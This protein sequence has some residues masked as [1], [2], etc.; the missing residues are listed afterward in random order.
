[1]PDGDF[2][3][4]NSRGKYLARVPK[5]GGDAEIILQDERVTQPNG[6]TV[7]T[8]GNVYIAD[9]DSGHVFKLSPE[10]VLTSLVELPGR[11]NAHNVYA[12][13]MLYV[14]KIW[15]HVV[16][17]VDL[18]TG[19]YGII[20]GT[21]TAGYDDG[22][23]GVATIEEPNSIAFDPKTQALYFNTHRGR[24]GRNQQA[25]MVVRKLSLQE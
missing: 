16:Y 7:D 21:G 24:M 12:N 2:I 13:D 6:V 15:D 8:E 17:Q 22:I 10:G 3:V 19:A 20:S 14:T 23:V 25:H 4:A 1:M 5:G 9:L 11:G 18:K